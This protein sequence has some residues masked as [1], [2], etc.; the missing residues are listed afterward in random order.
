MRRS[1][2]K[3]LGKQ[4]L[5]LAVAALL[6]V[7]T[8][9]LLAVTGAAAAGGA[10]AGY[11]YYRGALYR[12]YPANL[13]SAQAAVRAALL[14]LRMPV[15]EETSGSGE[16]SVSSQTADGST[17]RIALELVP[18][19]IPVEGPMTRIS[20]RVGYTGDEIVSARVLDQISLRLVQAAPMTPSPVAETAPP[21]LAPPL[22]ST[23]PAAG[24][25]D[26]AA[27]ARQP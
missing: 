2:H 26:L 4:A 7:N 27:P 5:T 19:R 10:T 18:G 24:L 8:G 14:D 15:L 9:C 3:R 12:E 11:L 1:R 20:V 25:S 6:L 23:A 21:P 16:A 13:E 22:P 17:V